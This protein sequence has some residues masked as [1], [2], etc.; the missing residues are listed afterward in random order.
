VVVVGPVVVVVGPLV[1]GAALVVVS[2]VVVEIGTVV[3]GP[4][5]V[6]GGAVMGGAVTVGWV[7]VAPKVESAM[8]VVV[9]PSVAGAS[10]VVGPVVVVGR[11]AASG[12]VSGVV[13]DRAVVVAGS[14]GAVVVVDADVAVGWAVTVGWATPGARRDGGGWGGSR[15]AEATRAARTAVV[16]PKATSSSLQGHRG[17]ARCRGGGVGMVYRPGSTDSSGSWMSL[18]D[19]PLSGT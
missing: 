11:L 18:E 13:V 2:S 4:V 7:V 15:V 12:T 8:V 5:V 17:V 16:S 10:A 14:R 19:V 6:V 1:V 3:L 9:S